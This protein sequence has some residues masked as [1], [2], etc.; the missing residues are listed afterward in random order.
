MILLANVMGAVATILMA[1]L[2]F[3]KIAI[4]ASVVISWV[5]ADP[6]NPIVRAIRE[7]TE[8]LFSRVRRF[9]PAVFGR[10]DL[11]PILVLLALQFI[12]VAIVGS[13]SDYAANL[14]MQ[15]IRL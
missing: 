10:I 6:Y 9:V 1:V 13:L 5:N 15:A 14:R 4:I 7:L 8:P 3:F 2:F 11:S 12:E